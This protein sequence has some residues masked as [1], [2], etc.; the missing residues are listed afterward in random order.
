MMAR[1]SEGGRKEWCMKK[2]VKVRG[3]S[4]GAW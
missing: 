1:G 4:G 2:P 3:G